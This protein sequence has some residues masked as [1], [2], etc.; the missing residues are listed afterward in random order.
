[1]KLAEWMSETLQ[2]V[3]HP[4]LGRHWLLYGLA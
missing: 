3:N 2:R 4:S 1:M